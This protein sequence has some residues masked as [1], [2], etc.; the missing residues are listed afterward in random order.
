MAW[1]EGEHRTTETIQAP[2]DK[3]LAWFGNPE[4]F[5]A[6]IGDLQTLDKVDDNTW[7][8]VLTERSE[9]GIRFQPDYTVTYTTDGDT[10]RWKTREGCNMLT[11]G[12]AR[13][14]AAGDGARVEYFESIRTEIPVPKLLA[15]FARGLV[16]KE[17]S[18]GISSYV[19]ASKR[20]LEASQ[21]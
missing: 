6:A 8:F 7:R 4:I 21:G 15:S 10:V 16:S 9:K 5:K 11:T 14:T 20:K 17:V 12:E 1:F 18:K 3:V 13:V 19:R 2:A